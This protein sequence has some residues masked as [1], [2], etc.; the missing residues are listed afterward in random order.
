LER[1]LFSHCEGASSGFVR[2]PSVC[3]FSD[4]TV[5]CGEAALL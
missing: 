2:R 1:A 4:G 3:H 5:W